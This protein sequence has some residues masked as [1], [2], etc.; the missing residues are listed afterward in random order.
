M[1]ELREQ[2]EKD[3]DEYI[4]VVGITNE[5]SKEDLVNQLLNTYQTKEHY[6]KIKSFYPFLTKEDQQN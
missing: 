3:V 1:D 6:D 2:L 5:F 4:K